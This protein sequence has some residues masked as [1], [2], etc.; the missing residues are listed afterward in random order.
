MAENSQNG[1]KTLWEKE[2]LLVTSKF[3]F[4]TM[5]SKDVYCRHVKTRACLGKGYNILWFISP[6]FPEV[7]SNTTSD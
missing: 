7:Q 6:N 1:L 3:S 4:P 5:F 2:K